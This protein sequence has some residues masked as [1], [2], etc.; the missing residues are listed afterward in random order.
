MKTDILTISIPV[1]ERFDYFE[2]AY[3][4]IINQTIVP[5]IIVIDN[6]SSHSNFSDFCK[7]N[8]IPYFRNKSNLGMFGNWNKCFE[9]ADTEYVMILGDDDFLEPT[10]VEKFLRAKKEH[11]DIDIWFS[12][13]NVY[14]YSSTKTYKNKHILPFGKNNGEEILEYGVKYSLG[15]P[16]IS[17][18]IKKEIFTG[19]YNEE[20][21]SN[22]WVWIYENAQNMVFYGDEER[23]L[24]YGKHHLQD[25]KNPITH[26]KCIASLSFLYDEM[27][28]KLTIS[29][30]KKIAKIKSRYY[31]NFFYLN[32]ENDFLIN[33]L[34][35]TNKYSSFLSENTSV[36]KRKVLTVMPIALK[37]FIF[38]IYFRLKRTV[39]ASLLS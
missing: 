17:S 38:K 22:D 16:V 26:L 10:Y 15:F 3:K 28:K 37:Q 33:Y 27:A 8:K 20:H 35:K 30:L 9:Y 1:F 34:N 2:A 24:N 12:D 36:F 14:D 23:L 21:G 18:V 7:K 19:F 39:F 29:K 5:K 32:T 4:S 6:H 11:Q 31:R 13:F 25:S